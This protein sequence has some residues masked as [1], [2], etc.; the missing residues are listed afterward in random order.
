[1]F[2]DVAGRCVV[3][4][5]HLI[6]TG[7]GTTLLSAAR[8]ARNAGARA[9]LAVTSHGLFVGSAGMALADPVLDRIIVTDSVSPFRLQGSRAAA[10]IEILRAAPLFAH[11]IRRLAG[12]KRL[13][14][15]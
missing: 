11:A 15:Q 2:A 9:V 14:L 8:A 3:I 12:I 1:M 6:G 7:T 4:V 13:R 10:C 5:D